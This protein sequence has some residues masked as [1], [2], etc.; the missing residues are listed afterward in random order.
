MRGGKKI[1]EDTTAGLESREIPGRTPLYRQVKGAIVKRLLGGLWQPG[2]VLPNESKIAADFG[3]SQGTVRKALNELA[4]EGLV[5][6]RQGVGTFVSAHDSERALFHF[7]RLREVGKTELSE[8]PVSV[9]HQQGQLTAT[10]THSRHLD[11]SAGDP[12]SWIRR[13]RYLSGHAAIVE[14]IVIPQMLFPGL[15]LTPGS[16]FSDELYVLYQKNYAVTVHKTREAV[17]ASTATEDEAA[18]L[19]MAAGAPIIEV[20]RIAVALDGARVEWRV[21]RCRGEGYYYK[22]DIG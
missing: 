21:T 14:D 16:A 13:L 22:N 17:R 3:V 9:V 11:V 15:H 8:V 18:L 4:A 6:R 2:Q 10:P 12:L 19:G 1:D 7:F 5:D 20:D